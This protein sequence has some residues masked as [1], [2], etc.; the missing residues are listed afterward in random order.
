[1]NPSSNRLVFLPPE[2]VS[3]SPTSTI[4]QLQDKHVHPY[5]LSI[6]GGASETADA[7]LTTADAVGWD[8]ISAI[9]TDSMEYRSAKDALLGQSE[10]M[11]TCVGKALAL[12]MDA[13]L[14]DAKEVLVNLGSQ[15]GARAVALFV[16]PEH[17]RLLLEASQAL[18]L[19]GRFVWVSPADWSHSG[20]NIEGLQSEVAGALR[21]ETHSAILEDF[22]NYVR[23]LTYNNRMN[24]PEDWFFEIYETVHQCNLIDLQA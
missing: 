17:L 1:T 22:N 15:V 12:P 10:S 4:T 11:A 7:I 21:F 14:D 20:E 3:I 5:F 24:I 13:T 2:I 23:N 6:R 9:Y 8:Y 18:S 16:K 19:A